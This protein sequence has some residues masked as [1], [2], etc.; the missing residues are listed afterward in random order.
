MNTSE[1][2]NIASL[3]V[4]D[5]TAII[6]E[7]QKTSYSRLLNRVLILANSLKSKGLKSGDRIAVIEVNSPAHI[8]LYFAAAFLDLVYVPLNFRSSQEELAH[9][10]KDASP[11]I[12]FS[13]MRYV[14]MINSLKPELDFVE[15]FFTLESNADGWLEYESLISNE[16]SSD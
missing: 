12:I 6:F 3:I 16:S 14:S 13:G 7:D 15:R 5:R 4:P 8:E 11:R 1:F 10:L 9:M 2:I